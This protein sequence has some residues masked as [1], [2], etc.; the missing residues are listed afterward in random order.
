L[1]VGAQGAETASRREGRDLQTALSKA[2]QAA[3]RIDRYFFPRICPPVID[4]S[5]G[6]PRC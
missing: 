5:L 3:F 2:S 1:S 4:P 6:K